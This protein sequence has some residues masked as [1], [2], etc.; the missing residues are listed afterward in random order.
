[1]QPTDAEPR[2]T[3]ALV[4]LR[5]SG[6]TTVGRL[7]AE[8]QGVPFVDLD[9]ALLQLARLDPELAV[10]P[11]AG[12]LLLAVGEPRFRELELAA[13][14][15]VL[16]DEAACVLATGGGV[17]ETERARELL[18]QHALCVR[19]HAAPRTLA[20]RLRADP[21][22]RPS[23]TGADPADE[24]VELAARRDPLYAALAPWGL[25][26]GSFPPQELAAQLQSGL[27]PAARPRFRRL[28]PESPPEGA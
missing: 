8:R 15:R 4:G 18:R 7:L 16:A 24:L 21:T 27:D 26:T 28:L 6:K 14:E 5:C 17:V 13:L 11:G 19:L 3:L 25:D 20:A 22:R 9:D 12:A 23:L 2:S 10:H 1:M